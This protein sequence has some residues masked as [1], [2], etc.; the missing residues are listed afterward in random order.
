MFRLSCERTLRFGSRS[1]PKQSHL[2]K[3]C[4]A[5]YIKNGRVNHLVFSISSPCRRPIVWRRKITVIVPSP[6]EYLR[7]VESRNLFQSVHLRRLMCRVYFY[8]CISSLFRDATIPLFLKEH[9]FF[10]P[11]VSLTS[12]CFPIIIFPSKEQ[13]QSTCFICLY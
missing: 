8:Q 10:V 9:L 7:G 3:A 13:N 11:F 2:Q 4:S 6:L 5:G 12:V 1:L